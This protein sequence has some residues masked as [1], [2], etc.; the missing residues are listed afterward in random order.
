[1][2]SADPEPDA[3]APSAVDPAPPR[4]PASH[5]KLSWQDFMCNRFLSRSLYNMRIAEEDIP[6]DNKLRWKVR[7]GLSQG[8]GRSGPADWS[9]VE[10][11]NNRAVDRET[12][13]AERRSGRKSGDQAVLRVGENLELLPQLLAIAL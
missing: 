6:N 1:M 13:V 8:K 10:P 7:S 9:L 5:G 12:G 2:R 3:H 4:S 11:L